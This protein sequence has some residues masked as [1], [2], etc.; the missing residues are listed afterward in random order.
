MPPESPASAAAA[1]SSIALPAG[2][3]FVMRAR[4]IAFARWSIPP[5]WTD[6]WIAADARAHIQATGRDAAGRKQYRYHPLWT[7]ERDS[8]KYHRMLAFAA[9]L[10]AIRRRIAHDLRQSAGLA[11]V[12]AGHGGR[13]ART[14][15]LP[16]RQRRVRARQRLPWPHHAARSACEDPRPPPAFRVPRQERRPAVDRF[17]RCAAGAGGAHLPGPAGPGAVPV[18]GRQ[19]HRARRVIV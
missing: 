18:R 17:R 1:A 6:V 13:A 7:A 2:A 10:P 5:A 9:A 11:R 12:R 15:A 4:W 16:G 14:H 19:G 3:W 8:T